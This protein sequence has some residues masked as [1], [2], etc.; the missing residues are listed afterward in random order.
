MLVS[1]KCVRQHTH[2]C[3]QLRDFFAHAHFAVLE[4]HRAACWVVSQAEPVAAAISASVGQPG[5]A[6]PPSTTIHQ[7]KDISPCFSPDWLARSILAATSAVAAASVSSPA[8]AAVAQRSC[9]CLLNI[10][11]CLRLARCRAF[12]FIELS[13]NPVVA[14]L[15]TGRFAFNGAGRGRPRLC[16]FTQ[17]V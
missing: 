11:L 6:A 16:G 2:G 13:E 17:T 14:L 10:A 8:F 15:H 3:A 5:A 12:V 1:A 4:C 7:L 9:V